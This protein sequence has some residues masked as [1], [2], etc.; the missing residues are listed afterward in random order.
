MLVNR[1]LQN[2]STE[3][4]DSELQTIEKE[5]KPAQAMQNSD[6]SPVN[7]LRAMK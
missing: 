7:N 2:V 4:E 6:Y 3:F 5:K 1:L